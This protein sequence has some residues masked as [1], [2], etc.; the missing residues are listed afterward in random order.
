LSAVEIREV[1]GKRDLDAFIAAGH[2]A[3]SV[4][5]HW[6]A[7]LHTELQMA[8]D[9]KH[10]PL[11]QENAIKAFVALQDGEPAG[12]IAAIV[13]RA[14]LAK[15]KDATGHF[16]LIEAIDSQPVFASLIETASAFLKSH[17]L[18][19]IQ[20]PFSLTI[21]HESGLLV[22]G[23]DAPHVVRT[24]HAP[25]HYHKHIEALGFSKSMDLLAAVCRIA[26]SDFP[27]RVARLVARFA[28]AREMRTYGLTLANWNTRFPLVLDLYNDAW[29]FNWG[30]TPVS[31][32]EARMIANLTL[33][34][35]K[36][37]WIRIAEWQG[38]P[39]A[40]VSQIPDV[41]EAMKGLDGHLL[42]FGFA[43]LMWRIHAQGTRMTRLPMIGVA[44]RWRGT[45][46]G[47]IGVSLLL[48]EAIQQARKAGVEEMEISWMLETNHAILNLVAS[49]PAHP[50]RRFRIYEKAI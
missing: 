49:L 4:N 3:Q 26:D 37:S 19:R 39:I 33:P 36:P 30:S 5:P 29:Q 40:I 46:V 42:P 13:N 22:E 38:E 8:F 28:G 50:T 15:Y 20:G 44:S 47:S 9:A 48:A 23:F 6:V 43:K 11:M 7:P 16:G 18:S 2:R 25:P 17:G 31:P 35:A 12:R 10:S 1:Q 24:N 32:A 14:H 27:E 45:R 41:N 21:N 34:V